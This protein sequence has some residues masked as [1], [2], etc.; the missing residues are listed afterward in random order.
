MLV[1]RLRDAGRLLHERQVSAALL[2]GPLDA[3]FDVADGVEVL[4][5]LAPVAAAQPALQVVHLAADR[6]EV[7][8]SRPLNRRACYLPNFAFASCRRAW[9]I[10]SV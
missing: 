3:A 1:E 8:A 5:D 4:G 9:R 6:I 10:G 7:A 2:L